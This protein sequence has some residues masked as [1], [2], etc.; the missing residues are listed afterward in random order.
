VIEP[1]E[2]ARRFATPRVAAGALFVDEHGRILLL[3]PT[4][5]QYW[6]IPGG[7]IEHGES[8][9][10]ACVREVREEIGLDVQITNLLV[11]DWA[12]HPDEGDKMLFVFDG[13][14]LSD[15]QLKSIKFEDG[16]IAEWAFLDD[17]Q[18]D[19]RTIPRLARRLRCALEARTESRCTYLHEGAVPAS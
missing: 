1:A 13:G 5:K 11:I 19:E 2:S 9:L 10:D 4:Y 8:P 17:R 18:L 7:Y 12:P 3:R 16:E 6:D 15:A 14:T